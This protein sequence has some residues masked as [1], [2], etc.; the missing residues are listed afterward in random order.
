MSRVS[1]QEQS[2]A[3]FY[4]AS[5]AH[6]PFRAIA[7]F[8]AR[9]DTMR[10]SALAAHAS[11]SR[12]SSLDCPSSGGTHQAP[13]ATRPEAVFAICNLR[14]RLRVLEHETSMGMLARFT[15]IPIAKSNI[16]LDEHSSDVPNDSSIRN[17]AGESGEKINPQR[18]LPSSRRPKKRQIGGSS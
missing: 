5:P 12:T 8:K 4:T 16:G 2:R 3:G 9:P 7:K 13:K 1:R 14:A 6:R 17:F 15:V 10:T 11:T 18:D